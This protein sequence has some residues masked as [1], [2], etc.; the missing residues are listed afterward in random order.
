MTPRSNAAS[1]R[2]ATVGVLIGA[3]A[4]YVGAALAGS[5]LTGSAVAGAAVSNVV[6]FAAGMAWLRT[7]PR[8]GRPGALSRVQPSGTAARRF[9]TLTGLSLALCWLVGQAA[10]VWIYSLVGSSGFDRHE[11]AKDA[12]PVWMTLLVVLVLAPLGEEMLMRGVAYGRLRRHMPPIG[13]AVLSSAVFSALHL[14]LVQIVAT[15]PLGILLA[16]VYEQTG[17]LAPLVGLHA[18]FNALSVMVPVAVVASFSTL[19]FVL[20]AGSV[21]VLVLAQLY[22]SLGVVPDP[23]SVPAQV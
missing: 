11:A 14:N 3:V 17:R 8:R 21:L 23:E 5:L 20:I 22:R 9:W 16:A 10:S 4:L 13:A 19:A 1:G 15:L 12:A 2:W 7:Q 6:V 18:V